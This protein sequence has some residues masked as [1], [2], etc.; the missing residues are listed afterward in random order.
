MA[1]LGPRLFGIPATRA[2]VVAV[3]RRGP[4]AWSQVGRWDL[5]RDRY[6]PGA[7]IRAN[8]YPQR[9]DLSPDGRWLCYA[10][11]KGGARWSVGPTYMAVSRLPW[12]AALAAWPTCGTWTRGAHFVERR[13]TW[14]VGEPAE[15]DVRPLRA[16][17]GM[18]LTRPAC[19]AV[20]RR[21]GWTE[22]ED[23]PPR[24]AGDVWDEWRAPAVTMEKAR[25]GS[26]GR[27]RLA[28]SGRFA[29]FREGPLPGHPR[30][31]RY[32]LRGPGLA[33]PLGDV[34]WADWAADGT[35]L[36]A[37]R[38]GRLERRR[39]TGSEVALLRV[40]ADL[41]GKAPRPAPAPPDALRW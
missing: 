25:P 33:L 7:W 19:F 24:D 29:A 11:L 26:R 18:A 28:V 4:S 14:E 21:R 20:E 41:A 16:V 39:W 34:Q 23:S 31:V 8:L 10:T 12:L 15:G 17:L 35:L 32:E 13:R 1:S 36:V 22:S 9:C 38:A 40:V 30:E 2:P 3:L 27:L 5:G 37:T 6:E